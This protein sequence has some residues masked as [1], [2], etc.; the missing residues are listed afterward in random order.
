MEK[1]FKKLL[2]EEFARE[3]TEDVARNLGIVDFNEKGGIRLGR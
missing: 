1:Y 2:N 3:Q